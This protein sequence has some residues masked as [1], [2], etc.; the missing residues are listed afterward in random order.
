MK[1]S[2]PIITGVSAA[3]T[4]ALI[5]VLAGPRAAGGPTLPT[6][7]P[8]GSDPRTMVVTG[9]VVTGAVSF[10]EEVRRS[11]VAPHSV[12][13]SPSDRGRDPGETLAAVATERVFGSA[14]VAVLPSGDVCLSL[15]LS[16]WEPSGCTAL[17]EALAGRLVL[18]VQASAS[19][20][21]IVAGI[22]PDG[23]S[24][25]SSDKRTVLIENNVWMATATEGSSFVVRDAV[26]HLMEV[27]ILSNQ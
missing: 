16:D 21:R 17:S 6:A 14:V 11:G 27:G 2:A 9:D 15:L 3:A 10:V 24:V 7:G 1:R 25:V 19:T 8:S 22:V 5:M 4:A 26:G 23:A 18:D 13:W 12:G 20:Q